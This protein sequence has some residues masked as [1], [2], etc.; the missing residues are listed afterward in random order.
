MYNLT[1]IIV[2]G[3]FLCI[4]AIN[5]YSNNNKTSDFYN[6]VIEQKELENERFRELIRLINE[7]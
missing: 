4:V 5:E 6:H 7:R 3:V 1:L 2:V